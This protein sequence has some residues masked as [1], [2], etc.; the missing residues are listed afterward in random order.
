M[1]QLHPFLDG[2]AF[3]TIIYF[4]IISQL[5]PNVIYMASLVDNLEVTTGLEY[6]NM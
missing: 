6:S 4:L 1:Q 2:K 3:L 5:D